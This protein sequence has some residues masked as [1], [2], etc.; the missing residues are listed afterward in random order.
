[1][2]NDSSTSH[3]T[4]ESLTQYYQ[5]QKSKFSDPFRLRM[6]R[7]LSWLSKA[8]SVDD[9]DIRFITLWIAFNAAYAREVALFT[10]SSERSEFR[11]FIQ[12][13]CSLDIDQ[14][15]YKLVWEK[16]SGS[17]RI[18]LDNQYTFQPFWDYQNGLISQQAWEEDFKR[19]K[20][21]AHRALSNKDTDTVLAVVFD[22]L[23]T[24]R[25]QIM[26][27]GATHN[28]QVNRS[29]IKDSGAIL[30]AILPLMLEIMMANHSKMDWGKPFY[31]V[32]N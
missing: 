23:Y 9:E 28:S 32:V 7:S 2:H 16:Y 8:T 24:L 14:Q 3:Q 5:T 22:R 1:M 31:P 20:D 26:H 10:T 25:N 29:Q 12:L 21:K 18:L 30:F 13:I 27:G 15:V 4:L 6:H 17:I 19:A 11:R